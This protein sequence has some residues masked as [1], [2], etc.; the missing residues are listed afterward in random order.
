M[1]LTQYI[2]LCLEDIKLI[3]QLVDTKTTALH[4][5]TLPPG[6]HVTEAPRTRNTK[7]PTY[8]TQRLDETPAQK[9]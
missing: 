7:T 2:P 9:V 6:Y 1:F 8:V 4:Y 5:V 3:F